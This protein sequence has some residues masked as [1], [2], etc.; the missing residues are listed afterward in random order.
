M[1]QLGAPFPVDIATQ[2]VVDM[3]KQVRIGAAINNTI[4]KCNSASVSHT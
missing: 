1:L 2:H 4:S 3:Q